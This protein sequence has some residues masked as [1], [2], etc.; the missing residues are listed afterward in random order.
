MPE[1]PEVE[2]VRRYLEPLVVGRTIIGAK[3][4]WHRSI[5]PS[6]EIFVA[7]THNQTIQAVDRH[8]KYLLL[9]LNEALISIHLRMSGR[10]FFHS[11]QQ[12][13]DPYLRALIQLDQ[14]VQIHLIDPRKFARMALLESKKSLRQVGKDFINLEVSLDQFLEEF[15]KL[16]GSVKTKLLSQLPFSGI[17]NIYADEA[18]WIAQIHPLHQIQTLS[19]KQLSLL[20]D[21]IMT[22]LEQGV[23]NQGT[24]LGQSK[25]NFYSAPAQRGENAQHLFVYRRTGLDCCRCRQAIVRIKIGGRSSH[26]CP[27]C[28]II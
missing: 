21:A 18:L 26:Y 9:V 13:H 3:A 1:G 4:L 17:G 2:T 6:E 28:Q 22:T 23:K 5:Q 25:T 10:V 15:S 27:K 8:G 11:N 19:S 14:Q 24:S 20:F 16:K 12:T 7:A